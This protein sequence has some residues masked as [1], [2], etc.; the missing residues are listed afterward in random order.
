VPL[1]YRQVVL[2]VAAT[3]L[4]LAHVRGANILCCGIGPVEAAATTARALADGA[5][6]PVL[7]IG[8]AGARHLEPGALVIGSEAIYADSEDSASTFPRITRATPH[9]TLLAAAR[10]ALPEAHVLPIATSARVGSGRSFADVE[11]M[12]GFA[13]LRAA[14][15][16]GVPALEVRCVSNSFDASRAEWRIDE[17]L[18]ALARATTILIEAFH[19]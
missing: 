8:I 18:A 6:G 7:H 2:V 15:A 4:E 9:E 3:E 13:V 1:V 16:A 17:A 12:E 11:A 14:A 5:S 19:A 10:A